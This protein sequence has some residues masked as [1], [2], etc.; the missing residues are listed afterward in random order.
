MLF[1]VETGGG[2]RVSVNALSIATLNISRIAC[3]PEPA[4]DYLRHPLIEYYNDGPA[5]TVTE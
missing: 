2:Y 4:A 1:L 5:D 3:A